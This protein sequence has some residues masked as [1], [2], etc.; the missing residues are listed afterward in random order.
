[1][2]TQTPASSIYISNVLTTKISLHITEV[3]QTVQQNLEQALHERVA[4]KCIE[5]GYIR[6]SS[7]RIQTYSAGTIR[8]ENVDF[9]VVYQCDIACPTEG[10]VLECK[11]KTVTKA[12]V[13]A[14]CIDRDGNAPI[15]VFVARDHH[16]N[17]RDFQHVKD[18]DMV[19]VSVIGTRWELNDP[20]ICVIARLV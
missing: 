3:G 17:S 11:V 9:Q 4:N 7:I 1:M 19:R 8:N 14:E 10:Q 5:E 2:A 16:Q 20:N 18:D 12:G 15:T 6:P 13:H